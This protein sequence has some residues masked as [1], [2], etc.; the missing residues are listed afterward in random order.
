MKQSTSNESSERSCAELA[1]REARLDDAVLDCLLAEQ[2]RGLSHDERN[3]WLDRHPDLR[4]DL[5]AFFRDRDHIDRLAGLV[6][7][8]TEAEPGG[9]QDDSAN[10][11]TAPWVGAAALSSPVPGGRQSLGDY[12]LLE[13]IGKGGMGLVYKARQRSLKRIVALKMILAGAHARPEELARFR[14]EAEAVAR[15]QHSNIVQI[16]EVGDVEGTAFFSLEFVEG[17][18]L[19]SYL[20]GASLTPRAAAQLVG[21]LAQAIHYA[22]LQGIIHRDL[23]PANIL[24]QVNRQAAGAESNATA[25]P[26]QLSTQR[27]RSGTRGA[28][29]GAIDSGLK[30]VP[31]ITDFGLAKDLAEESGQTKSGTVMGTPAYMATEQAAG[32]KDRI[33]PATDVYG[34]GA[35]LYELLTGRP[36]FKA[37]TP[38]ETVHQVLHQ[39]VVSPRLLYPKLDRDLETICLKCLQKDPAR[40]YPSAAALADDLRCYLEGRPIQARPVSRFVKFWRLCRRHPVTSISL[41]LALFSFFALFL[42]IVVFNQRLHRELDRNESINRDLQMALT[43]QM[44]DR[45]DSDLRQLTRIPTLMAATLSLRS[46]WRQDQL[47]TWLRHMLD[48]DERLFG[49][50]IAFEPH[51]FDQ[52][53]D[54]A[55]YGHRVKGGIETKLLL[56]PAYQPL[57]REWSWYTETKIQQVA[58]W[59]EP[60][61]DHEGGG[62]IPMITYSAPIWRDGKFAGVV[63]ADL[64]VAYFDAMRRWLDEVNLGNEG[65]AFVVSPTGTIISHPDPRFQMPLKITEAAAFQSDVDLQGMVARLLDRRTGAVRAVDPVTGERSVFHFAPIVSAHWSFVAVA[66]E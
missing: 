39:E 41:G 31:K 5:A 12:E 45:I 28:E 58:R 63:T 65:Y 23:K 7:R 29:T 36:P 9:A 59:T 51:Q 18:S 16:Y 53:E 66:R 27:S 17:G 4:D 47:E 32:H 38:W 13:E 43:K 20:R 33:G 34:L 22:H 52:R 40:R 64:S 61:L 62:G 6:R 26:Q 49:T 24:L 25:Q 1:E 10:R 2:G 37:A 15:L 35:I 8:L 19:S 3:A 11:V 14:S 44:A 48:K 56:P 57:Y 54:F 42:A 50:C 46:D 30:L 55:L 60:F 21:T